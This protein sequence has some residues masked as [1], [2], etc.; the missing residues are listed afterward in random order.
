MDELYYYI[1]KT[2]QFGIC[3]HCGNSSDNLIKTEI[4]NGEKHKNY[5]LCYD[6]SKKLNGMLKSK[7][8]QYRPVAMQSSNTFGTDSDCNLNTETI[9]CNQGVKKIHFKPLPIIITSVVLVVAIILVGLYFRPFIISSNRKEKSETVS[10]EN[11]NYKIDYTD[12]DKNIY[13]EDANLE[14]ENSSVP[15]VNINFQSYTINLADRDGYQYEVILKLSPWILASQSDTLNFAW[16]QLGNRNT[17]P[18]FNDWKIH[19]R[20][21]ENWEYNDIY[22][23]V[24][25]IS[26]KNVSS[27]FDFSESNPGEPSITFEFKDSNSFLLG[28][29]YDSSGYKELGT[30]EG[31]KGYNEAVCI[32]PIMRQNNWGPISIIF[33][34]P[35]KISPNFPNG[36]N[37]ENYINGNESSLFVSTKWYGNGEYIITPN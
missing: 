16:S 7:G 19:G 10:S 27:G 34:M 15:F 13:D 28:K 20:D 23:M 24:G 21:L 12:P 2:G 36:Q 35:D 33:A 1:L 9:K 32:S 17:L 30:C 5:L 29:G 31:H 14:L 25:Q 4:T 11:D 6:C 8:Y 37:Y 18:D 22:Y 26:V 3:P